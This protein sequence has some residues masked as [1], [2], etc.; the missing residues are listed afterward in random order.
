MTDR[1]E[2]N[3]VAESTEIVKATD[4][5]SLIDTVRATDT[6]EDNAVVTE[7][8]IVESH[9]VESI[10]GIEEIEGENTANVFTIPAPVKKVIPVINIP[11]VLKRRIAHDYVMI[12]K[13]N[14]VCINIYKLNN[15]I[16]IYVFLL[17]QLLKFPVKLTI[18]KLMN[19]YL[20]SITE[21]DFTTRCVY[22]NKISNLYFINVLC[23]CFR[24]RGI[25][26]ALTL[27]QYFNI[28]IHK[29]LLYQYEREQK[30]H[31][32]VIITI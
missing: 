27:I 19:S 13:H 20:C 25:N 14:K 17:F 21:Q 8:D 3:D 11:L 12:T 30:L 10:E 1:I 15:C 6:V 24:E 31:L 26:I 32:K 9:T 28:L 2:T 7:S 18:E 22:N 16:I 4:T 23:Y 5:A 29:E